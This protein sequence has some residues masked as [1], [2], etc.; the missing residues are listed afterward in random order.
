MYKTCICHSLEILFETQH[1][2]LEEGMKV[3]SKE[4]NF[5]QNTKNGR[6]RGGGVLEM[7]LNLKVF[8]V[9]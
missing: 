7:F 9:S 1:L 8:L 6:K 3:R 2:L 4:V 5:I